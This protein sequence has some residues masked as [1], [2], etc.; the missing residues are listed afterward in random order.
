MYVI[1]HDNVIAYPPAIVV[2][3]AL[4]DIMENLLAVRRSKNFASL[5]SARCKEDNRAVPKRR[6]M[7]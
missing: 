3:R 5:T 4:P 6:H 7:R 2:R 1:G